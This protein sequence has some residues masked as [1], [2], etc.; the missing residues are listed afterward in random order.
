M[1]KKIIFWMLVMFLLISS[2]FAVEMTEEEINQEIDNLISQGIQ[3]AKQEGKIDEFESYVQTN[4]GDRY[5]R[6]KSQFDAAKGVAPAEEEGIFTGKNIGIGGAV[7]VVLLV[8][9]F[10]R[11]K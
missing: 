8:L 4:L 10:A 9:F 7:I 2:V 3:K 11:K 5:S 1:N 6:F